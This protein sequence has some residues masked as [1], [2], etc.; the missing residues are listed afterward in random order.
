MPVAR[1]SLL[2]DLD[3]L[4]RSRVDVSVDAS[5]ARTGFVIATEALK[6]D[7]ILDTA[8]HPQVRFVASRITRTGPF[9]A[10][11]DGT[12]TIRGVSRPGQLQAE[13]FR[14]PGTDADDRDR[15]ALRLTGEVRR[16][17]F[18]ATGF[19]SM[20]GDV[21]TLDIVAFIRRQGS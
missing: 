6:S 21:V 9:A 12:F 3:D 17:E 10:R 1:A 11:L 13:I 5:R 2:I 16:S 15:L 4:S 7:D 14:Q 19:S 18:G 8:A 20:V